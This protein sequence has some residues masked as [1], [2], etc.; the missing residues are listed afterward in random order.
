MLFRSALINEKYKDILQKRF[1]EDLTLEGIAKARSFIVSGGE[2]DIERAA[3][4]VID[5]FRKCRIGKI[6]LD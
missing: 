6:T 4:A 5:D 3:N 1:G 2:L